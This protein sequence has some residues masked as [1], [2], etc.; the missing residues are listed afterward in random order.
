MLFST[1]GYR[2]HDT[3]PGKERDYVWS[4]EMMGTIGYRRWG[5]EWRGPFKSIFEHFRDTGDRLGNSRS[6]SEWPIWS[7]SV[8]IYR[9]LGMANIM[10]ESLAIS[11]SF[12]DSAD[13]SGSSRSAP[14]WP[15]LLITVTL[16]IEMEQKQGGNCFLGV[17]EDG[18]FK[19]HLHSVEQFGR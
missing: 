8:A 19:S 17:L 10:N 14:K 11:G 4:D 7:V 9:F 18:E 1:L 16:K 3:M 6:A 5:I 12:R 2:R 13:R 15:I